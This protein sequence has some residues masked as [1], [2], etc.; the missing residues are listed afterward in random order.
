[1][2]KKGFTL[3]EVLLTLTI[4]GVVAAITLPVVMTNVNDAVLETQVKKFYSQLTDAIDLY[5]Q[6]HEI[7]ALASGLNITQ[8]AGLF[9]TTPMTS[10]AD[11]DNNLAQQYT[12]MKG[13]NGQSRAEFFGAINE[14][15]PLYRLRDGSVFTI[16]ADIDNN[17]WVVAVDVNGTRTPN[18]YGVDT[19]K[20]VIGRDGRIRIAGSQGIDVSANNC[21]QNDSNGSC[22]AELAANNFRFRNYR[23]VIEA[24][25][26]EIT[27]N[28]NGNGNGKDGPDIKPFRPI[29]NG[30][31]RRREDL[32]TKINSPLPVKQ[33]IKL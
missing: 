14:N 17:P 1:M 13:T 2:L 10:L 20:M 19:W 4:I 33:K 5:K 3:A 29:D 28:G 22:I 21:L 8:F 27:D 25:S 32:S 12:N 31:A 15:N 16:R 24:G 18:L 26:D 9:D 30:E 6:Q 7:D 11:A 23:P